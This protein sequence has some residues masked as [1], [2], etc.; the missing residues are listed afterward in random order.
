MCRLL[1]DSVMQHIPFGLYL[2]LHLCL[3]SLYFL[4]FA[5]HSLNLIEILIIGNL[6]LCTGLLFCS[7]CSLN[8]CHL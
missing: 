6:C 5:V 8:L 1:L 4:F 2:S 7:C 3:L